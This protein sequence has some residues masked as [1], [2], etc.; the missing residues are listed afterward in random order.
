ML[1]LSLSISETNACA[2]PT[3]RSCMFHKDQ[4]SPHPDETASLHVDDALVTCIEL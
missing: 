2:T 3:F 1:Q 4:L